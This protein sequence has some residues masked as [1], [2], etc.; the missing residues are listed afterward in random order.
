MRTLSL[1][2]CIFTAYS[3]FF[4]PLLL[5]GQEPDFIVDQNIF[6]DTKGGK[7]LEVY[8][9]IDGYSLRYKENDQK[10][11]QSKVLV[12]L[13]ILQEG[14]SII[15]EKYELNSEE[16]S[17]EELRSA[18][19]EGSSITS[20]TQNLMDVHR[21]AL[22]PGSYTLTVKITDL[23]VDT[24]KVV[25]AVREFECKASV[26]EKTELSDVEFYLSR[27]KPA[28]PG[29]LTKPDGKD[30]IPM[31]SNSSF[32]EQD[33]LNFYVEIY[34]S[35]QLGISPYYISA[36]IRQANSEKKLDQYIYTIKKNGSAFDV[37][38]GTLMISDL[39]S[40]TYILSIEILNAQKE[41][42]L[43]T[44]KKF[45]VYK[46]QNE[47]AL[48][49]EYS[50]RYDIAYS[51]TEQELDYH[52]SCLRFIS[53]AT[54]LNF[55]KALKNY[56]DKKSFFYG[57]WDKRRN[58]PIQYTEIN[59]WFEYHKLIQYANQ[60]YKS[61]LR[62]GWET[63]RGRVLLVYG[64]PNDIQTYPS[65]NNTVPYDIW[66]Y[67][68]LGVQPG[69]IFVFADSDLITN[70][71]PLIHSTKYG[72]AN[73]PR[74]RLDLLSRFKDSNTVDYDNIDRSR[75]IRGEFFDMTPR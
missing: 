25:S 47:Q 46:Q 64:I 70:E 35:A 38:T 42:L 19:Q 27:S 6:S 45:F 74:W 3:L 71:Y 26:P 66:T 28:N 68:K 44:T 43:S 50:S 23:N 69:V 63:D 33:S 21:Y 40:Q 57:F 52:I 48:Q 75:D 16:Q 58:E 62:D 14:K 9:Y 39:P 15:T 29:I 60:K 37:F 17:K 5:Q 12:D 72:E 4:A 13:E 65:M 73:N 59:N 67:N 22:T 61:R 51:Y 20:A 49:A 31:V 55:V 7:Y 34:R 56:E 53:N 30:Y 2:A 54:E 41:V 10:K 32:I 18:K 8:L 36:S 11:F 1:F 24:P